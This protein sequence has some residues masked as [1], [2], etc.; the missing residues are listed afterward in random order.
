MT[1][2]KKRMPK[3]KTSGKGQIHKNKQDTAQVDQAP[4]NTRQQTDPR[5]KSVKPFTTKDGKL[6]KDGTRRGRP[7]GSTVNKATGLTDN[8]ERIARALLDA[9]LKSGLWPTSTR[10][11]AEITGEDQNYVRRLLRKPK[12]QEHLMKLL[13]L[14]GVILEQAFW[15]SLAFGLSVGDPKVM[16]LYAKITGKTIDRSEKK[17]T[18]EVLSPDGKPA[19]PVWAQDE[20]GDTIDAEIIEP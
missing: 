4:R 15:R 11:L 20:D 19:L 2:K 7:K 9:E 14:E 13:E 5:P 3:K 6:A 17:V 10:E 16:E 12:F 1:A 8:Q 18:V